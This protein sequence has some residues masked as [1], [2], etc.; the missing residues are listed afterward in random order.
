MGGH[1][2]VSI[3][4]TEATVSRRFELQLRR[5]PRRGLRSSMPLIAQRPSAVRSLFTGKSSAFGS[6]KYSSLL[7][8]LE[9]V[10]L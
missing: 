6:I 7:Q 2:P 10:Q 9:T 8:N 1:M 5:R 3:H 4:S